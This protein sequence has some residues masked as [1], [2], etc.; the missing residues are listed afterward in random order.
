MWSVAPA[1]LSSTEIVSWT[2]VD[3]ACKSH[4]FST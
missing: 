2:L 3:L 1:G 4:N